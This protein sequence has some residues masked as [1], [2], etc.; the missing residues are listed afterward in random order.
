MDD[1][2]KAALASFSAEAFSYLSLGI[3]VIL[4]R[5]FTRT[6]QVGIT[7]LTADDYFMLLTI[8]PYT[9][10]T[11]LAHAVSQQFN[12][13]TNSG[14][15]DAER[16]A[17]SPD[18][19]EWAW[20]VAGSKVQIA[21][22]CMYASVLWTIK[23]S[24]CAFYSRLTDGVHGYRVRILT[25]YAIIG[26]TYLVVIL[27]YLLSCQP[28]S[29]F[30]QIYPDPGNLCQPALSKVYVLLSVTLNI[31]TDA[32]LIL[33]PV[34]MLWGTQLPTF[35][36]L[37]LVVVF[38]GALFVMAAG[39]LRGILILKN[40][41]DGPR[42]G[43]AWAVRE[44]FVAVVTSCLPM[45]WGWLKIKLK[46]FLGSLLSSQSKKNGPE[47]GSIMLGDT[48]DGS[49]WRSGNRTHTTSRSITTRVMPAAERSSSDLSLNPKALGGIT[50][51]VAIS[52]SS[53]KAGDGAEAG[54][55]RKVHTQLKLDNKWS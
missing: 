34:P 53:K 21:G 19:E 5:T 8:V 38:S 22:W 40:P 10:E 4:L 1:S 51:Q 3:A 15:T 24:L 23:A 54:S 18:S 39:L 13:L 6:R 33:I 37:T 45:I 25:G 55:D 20:R 41:V 36:K 12:G 26:V 2:E 47:P 28:F 29:H 31:T 35:K 42:E 30:W 50:K 49:A 7:G 17:L 27:T 14:M 9:T 11:V 46:P 32:Y 52:V 43:S 48:N 16:A 44:S